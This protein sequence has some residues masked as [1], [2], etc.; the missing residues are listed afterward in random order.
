MVYVRQIV[1]TDDCIFM[2]D[3]LS[4]FINVG[5]IYSET[6][7][8]SNQFLTFIYDERKRKALAE[9][10]YETTCVRGTR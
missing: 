3:D 9:G 10:K 1:V 4:I 8:Y 6:T 5:R 7:F 2:L